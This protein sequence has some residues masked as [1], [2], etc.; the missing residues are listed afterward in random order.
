MQTIDQ[1]EEY[2]VNVATHPTCTC[3]ELQE[4]VWPCE[5]IMAWDDKE[6]RDFTKHFHDC[7]KFSSL[8]KLYAPR[9]PC[10]L[11]NDLEPQNNCFPPQEA[12][13][14]G[15][16]RLVC[17]E[18]GNRGIKNQQLA[19]D[20][21]VDD[22]GNLF[23]RYP[24]QDDQHRASGM[25]TIQ[26]TRRR[27]AGG[28]RQVVDAGPPSWPRRGRNGGKTRCSNCGNLGHNIRTCPKDVD[29]GIA[30]ED[31][32]DMNAQDVI[33]AQPS[34]RLH[35]SSQLINLATP[36]QMSTPLPNG[37]PV[38][39]QSSEDD[40][41]EGLQSGVGTTETR[42]CSLTDWRDEVELNHW[43]NFINTSSVHSD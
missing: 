5:H 16:H 32:P 13:T 12:V 26:D 14:K 28:I 10:F 20:E 19:E 43:V 6:G 18:S 17:I 40:D 24:I 42:N 25:P 21:F 27:R 8:R 7:W 11:I 38:Y 22:A 9:L 35:M 33:E 1:T 41:G 37:I 3:R 29:E 23:L 15:R 39:S 31:L 4:M 36:T 2:L 34:E 30:G